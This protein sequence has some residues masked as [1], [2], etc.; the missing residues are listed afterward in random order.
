MPII[1]ENQNGKINLEEIEKMQNEIDENESD[2][3]SKPSH[4]CEG[5][6]YEPKDVIR[7]WDDSS[8]KRRQLRT[9]HQR[10]VKMRKLISYLFRIVKAVY[11]VL[12]VDA[13]NRYETQSDETQSEIEKQIIEK[14]KMEKTS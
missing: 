11:Q 14:Y 8:H 3:I 6:K 9:R 13:K 1:I 5:R 12:L 7:D 4:Y 2:E 10:S